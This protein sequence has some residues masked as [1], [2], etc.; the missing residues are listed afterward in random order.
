MVDT[1]CC[2]TCGHHKR[3]HKMPSGCRRCDTAPEHRFLSPK[4]AELQLAELEN[5]IMA[6]DEFGKVAPHIELQARLYALE[7]ATKAYDL[8]TEVRDDPPEGEARDYIEE[9]AERYAKFL[10][11]R[12]YS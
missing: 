6:A 10:L 2:V 4:R 5:D 3:D 12:R 11:V 8:E 1:D 7:M 9:T